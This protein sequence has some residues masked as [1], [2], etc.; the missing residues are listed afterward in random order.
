LAVCNYP[1]SILDWEV[2]GS[3]GEAGWR[4][5]FDKRMRNENWSRAL[6]TWGKGGQVGVLFRENLLRR[7]PHHISP[8]RPKSNSHESVV[9]RWSSIDTGFKINLFRLWLDA[10]GEAFVPLFFPSL[11]RFHFGWKSSPH[12]MMNAKVRALA[13]VPSNNQYSGGWQ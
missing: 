12:V 8:S 2:P 1:F 5:L 10:D 13:S 9:S 4:D 7:R 11:E 3:P 6:Q